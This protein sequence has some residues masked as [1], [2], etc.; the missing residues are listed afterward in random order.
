MEIVR[1]AIPI[2][3]LVFVVS[4]MLAMGLSVTVSQVAAPLRNVRLV[5]ASLAANFVL[6]PLAAVGIGFALK[7]DGPLALGLLL[8]GCAAGAP[9][10]PKLAQIAKADLPFAI[11]LMVLLM[12]ITVGYIPAVVPLVLPGVSINPLEIARSLVLLMLLPLSA[13]LVF[14][15]YFAGVAARIKPA[16][17]TVS[18]LG[19]VVFIVLVTVANLR[20]VIDLFGTRG[21][22]A[23]IA[24]I[25]AGVAAGWMLGG[26]DPSVRRA[27]VLGTAQRNIAAAV[28]VGGQSGDERSVVMIVVVALIG[29]AILMPLSRALGQ[30]TQDAAA[31]PA[32][33]SN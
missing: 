10:L 29:F 7:L 9:F 5:L 15:A 11:G 22:L 18:S 21:I 25:A 3:L 27:V 26:R 30:R 2:A 13:A 33:R 24:F 20:N 8:L 17:A 32:A 12:V 19:L 31:A 16:I 23:G 4:S 1:A 28:V 14:N 6:M